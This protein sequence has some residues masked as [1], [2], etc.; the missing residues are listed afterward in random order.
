MLLTV[1]KDYVS[2]AIEITLSSLRSIGGLVRSF[3]L[4]KNMK[5]NKT[6]INSNLEKL[7]EDMSK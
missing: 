2:D 5:T 3:R 4:M 6:Y 7:H 1:D